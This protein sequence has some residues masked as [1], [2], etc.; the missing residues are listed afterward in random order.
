MS[1]ALA[2]PPFER[3]P[4][5][6]CR[7]A[8][9]TMPISAGP[10]VLV[11]FPS[12]LGWMALIGAGDVLKRL[13]F[14]H[15][16]S[17]AAAAACGPELLQYAQPGDW[18]SQ[19]VR[20]LQSYASGKPVD[21][22]DVRVDPGPLTE[23]RRRVVRCCRQIPYGKTISYGRLAAEAGSPRAA[24]AVGNCMAVNRI[25]LI[26]PCHRVLP[27]DGRPGSFSAPGGTRT[28]QRLL[29]LEGRQLP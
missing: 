1:K 16:S 15:R 13:T 8:M 24:R 21:F 17:H 6:G 3:R 10:G 2:I 19:L 11:V 18:N 27:A 26:I 4:A 25:P 9:H 5:V 14:G 12:R 28:K 7:V 29:A 20:R 23:F 22:C